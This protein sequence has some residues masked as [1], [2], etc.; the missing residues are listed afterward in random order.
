MIV[1]NPDDARLLADMGVPASAL[2][3]IRGVGVDLKRFPAVPEPSG[4]PLVM[5]PAR[6]LWDKGVAEFV[7]AA[8]RL[9]E[10]G[11][12][13]RFVLVG[14]PDPDN[15]AAVPE[16]AIRGWVDQGTVEWWGHRS[17]MPQVLA[18]ARIVCLPS[19][20]EGLPKVLLEAMAC[21]RAVVSCD[22]PGCREVVQDGENGLL[23]APRH[24]AALA[25]AI[26]RLLRDAALR[27]RLGMAGRRRVER[28]F[29]Q[30]AVI[31][32]TLAVYSEVLAAST[33]GVPGC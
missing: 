10:G 8:R 14:T 13:A 2:R 24:A 4:L 28:D 21:G 22:V 26:Q 19:Y 11:V 3:L 20:R 6:L 23:V 29:S 7:E 25:G 32:Q 15:P 18:Q 17:E 16:E 5:L 27:Q 12:D 1:Q 30:D 31:G 9:R 33:N